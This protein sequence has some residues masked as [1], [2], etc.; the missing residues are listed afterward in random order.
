MVAMNSPGVYIQERDMSD[1]VPS[2]S[3]STAVFGGNFTK[4]VVNE[5][6]QITSVDDLIENY[7]YPTND[8]YNEWYQC[9]NFLQYG[10]NLLISRAIND[11]GLAVMTRSEYRGLS[12]ALGYGT[13][14][15]GTSFYGLG[16]G[17]EII[18]VTD[19][20]NIEKG[21]VI[22]FSDNAVNAI[23]K[24]KS[25][26]YLIV[27]IAKK[28]INTNTVY[29]FK[30]DRNL[31]LPP[32]AENV[33]VDEWY[34]NHKTIF[35]I[36]E[37]YNGTCEALENGN[38]TSVNVTWKIVTKKYQSYDANNKLVTNRY[39]TPYNIRVSIPNFLDGSSFVESSI[40]NA[41]DQGN[42][43]DV[44]F[45]D[46]ADY[47]DNSNAGVLFK[48]NK[49]I[50][51]PND[52]DYKFDSL[53]FAKPGNSKL[54]F[55]SKTPGKYDARYKI[56]IALPRDFA[57]NDTDHIG[58]HCTRYAYDGL[59]ID[60]FFEYAPAENSAQIAV[61]I[62]DTIEEV[63]KETYIVSLDPDEV[64]SYNNSMFIE[65][66]INRQSSCVYVKC[67]KD[68][69][70]SLNQ[71]VLKYDEYGRSTGVRENITVPNIESYTL[72]CDVHGN[73]RGNLLSFSCASDS[74]IQTDDLLN[75]YDI[76]SNKDEVDIDIVI[77]N[78]IDNGE[79]AK[80]LAE[81]RADCI[82]FMG[83]PYEDKDIG[84][85]T[86][87]KSAVEATNNIIKYRNNLGYNS[88]FVSLGA[89]YKY[90]YDRYNDINRWINV[91][92]D[93]AGLRAQTS[94][95]YDTWWA[96][97]GL[98]R[99]QIK[100]VQK[101]SYNPNKTQQ[102]SLYNNGV[103]PIVSFSGDGTVLWGQKT[104]LKKASSFDRV[105]VRALFNT[106]ERALAKMSRY[107]V[108]EFND[109]FTRNNIVSKISPY[110]DT[111]KSGR[112]IND[113]RVVCDTTNNTPDIISRNQLIVDVYIKPNYVAEFILLRF[114][115]VGVNDF[116]IVVTNE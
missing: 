59:S 38:S 72:V 7:G 98:N 2:Q 6:R 26:R 15:F 48:T 86:V 111:I 83:I 10:N 79:S 34:Q 47:Q 115:N 51:N 30:L 78:E 5:F 56:A 65:K 82:A 32:E 14:T 52:W 54:K 71:I 97:A 28:T 60:S 99:G 46:Y 53:A 113:Y 100:N 27:D 58:N 9:Y 12:N 85:L 29:A 93:I 42:Q 39:L 84:I 75:A 77:A 94:E 62:Y 40:E 106:I 49:K 107:Q 61:F 44:N 109:S 16:S 80:T 64:D 110:L 88:M 13:D 103:N 33:T 74:S 116:S 20:T 21:D 89:N 45:I 63:M 19:N 92:G 18:I 50:L 90:Q 101:L 43:I 102:G 36:A 76:F 37:H 1:I 8:N 31:E 69:P 68:T 66:V 108:M 25:V 23:D 3:N 105:N 91:A 57:L 112:G 67:N 22:A 70:A 35:K 17:N 41:G 95:D 73:F 4:G 24:S 11:N 87:S 96:S 104:M 81:K 114:T 55:Y